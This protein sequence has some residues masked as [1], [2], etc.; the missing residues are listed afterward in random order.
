MDLENDFSKLDKI[1]KKRPLKKRVW[2]KLGTLAMAFT[3]IFSV[4][5]A[6]ALNTS[7]QGENKQEVSQQKDQN[8]DD[9]EKVFDLI[10]EAK[11]TIQMLIGKGNYK[12]AEK[13]SENLKNYGEEAKEYN[14]P[15]ADN[16]VKIAEDLKQKIKTSQEVMNVKPKDMKNLNTGKVNT[17]LSVLSNMAVYGQDKETRE[18]VVK[19]M[20]E[21]HVYS[22]Y[23]VLNKNT[24]GISQ[25]NVQP[26]ELEV[27]VNN[28][29]AS[30]GG[31]VI[32][33]NIKLE[34]PL[35]AN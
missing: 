3:A 11:E 35:E 1:T 29:V 17:Y 8:V 33:E 4:Q 30:V 2:K 21:F 25:I 26:V 31:H 6:D 19:K 14:L 32:G 9:R 15:D 18:S 7:N 16:I 27:E 12:E 34:V 23:P 24:E 20:V 10:V 5:Q 13:V 22:Q 28:G